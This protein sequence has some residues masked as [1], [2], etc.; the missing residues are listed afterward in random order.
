MLLIALFGIILNKIL[1]YYKDVNSESMSCLINRFAT[2]YVLIEIICSNKP[3][4]S[5]SAL[6]VEKLTVIKGN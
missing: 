5:T 4:F 2:Y 6:L 1:I 3:I